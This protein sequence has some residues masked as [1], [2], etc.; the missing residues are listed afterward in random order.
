[1]GLL[2]I[3]APALAWLDGRLTLL[4]EYA[5]L[6]FWGA[7]SGLLSMG[8]YALLSPQHRIAQG[9][10]DQARARHRLNAFDGELAEAWPLIRSLLGASLRQVGRAT[11]P[12]L[13][14]SIPALCVM[15]WLSNQ[16]G[17]RF[18]ASGAAAVTIS[19]DTYRGTL[20]PGE[21]GDYRIEI[22]DRDRRTVARVPLP[23]AI[24]VVEKRQWWN[25]LIGNPAGYLDPSA[26][27]QR[28]EIHL[29]R[30]NYLEPAPGWAPDWVRDRTPD[31]MAGWE[32]GFFTALLVVSLI[33]RQ[34]LGIH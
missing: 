32:F 21:N 12:A 26:P 29:P 8:F 27:M 11:G 28:I 4:P 5:R 6:L 9:K 15:L 16:Y 14:A 10:R 13:A 31:W 25:L 2:D 3:P 18:P 19:P 23:E 30:A 20:S 1:M 24:P 17:H 7:L 22:A 33:T 34:T